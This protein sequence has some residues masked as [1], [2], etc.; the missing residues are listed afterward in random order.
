MPA[1]SDHLGETGPLGSCADFFASLDKRTKEA[2]V[3]DPGDFRVKKYP[4]LRKSVLVPDDYITLRRV[5]GSYP[6]TRM[7]GVSRWHAEA[8]ESFSPEPPANWRTIHYVPAKKI[9]MPSLR[10]IVKP[11]ERNALG[12]P[13]YPPEKREA[14]FRTCAPVWEIQFEGKVV[15]I[16]L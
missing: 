12:I 9:D 5:L 6:L 8:H 2:G 3:L 10:Q 7:Y 16:R 1:R 4:Y 15:R 14:L 11:N 13:M